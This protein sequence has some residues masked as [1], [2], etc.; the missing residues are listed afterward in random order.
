MPKPYNAKANYVIC[1]RIAKTEADILLKAK[2]PQKL[3]KRLFS[4]KKGLK[5]F[6]L[7]I[8]MDTKPFNI[9]LKPKPFQHPY[10]LPAYLAFKKKRTFSCLL[11][12]K[13]FD[14]LW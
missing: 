7:L 5:I 13:R 9:L 1:T 12:Q 3:S 4:F 10:Y 8:Q 6:Q 2:I 11:I 14:R